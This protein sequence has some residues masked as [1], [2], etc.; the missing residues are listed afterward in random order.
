MVLEKNMIFVNKSGSYKA[1][2]EQ[3]PLYELRKEQ[4]ENAR[5]V[6]GPE[7]DR[8]ILQPKAENREKKRIVGEHDLVRRV[9]P[10]GEGRGVVQEVFGLCSVPSGSETDEPLWIRK[11]GHEGHGKMFQKH[12]QARKRRCPGH[13]C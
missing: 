8:K 6:S 10:N 1:S 12:S 3:L 2:H 13:E 5:E 4:E 7:M 9:D 11:E